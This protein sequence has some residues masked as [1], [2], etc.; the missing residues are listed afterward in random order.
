M[1]P[2]SGVF[3]RLSITISAPAEANPTEYSR[4]SAYKAFRV[5]LAVTQKYFT[6]SKQSTVPKHMIISEFAGK[7]QGH[8]FFLSRAQNTLVNRLSLE[9]WQLQRELVRTAPDTLLIAGQIG[10]LQATS[11]ISQIS[12]ILQDVPLPESHHSDC[13]VAWTMRAVLALQHLGIIRPGNYEEVVHH[14][15]RIS[16]ARFSGSSYIKPFISYLMTREEVAKASGV[17]G[18]SAYERLRTVPL[19]FGFEGRKVSPWEKEFV[20]KLLGTP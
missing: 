16:Y 10:K 13:G 5:G 20:R 19:D 15:L 6:V 18:L 17:H 4:L 9:K 12:Q 14:A 2:V 3:S 7:Q 1:R 11:Q 8:L